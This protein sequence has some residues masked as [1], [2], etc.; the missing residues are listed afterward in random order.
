M[1]YLFSQKRFIID[2]WQGPNANLIY[3]CFII[4]FINAIDLNLLIYL[5]VYFLFIYLHLSD[6][7]LPR[8]T[9][10]NKDIL[11]IVFF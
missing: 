7:C 2:V 8:S 4:I 9:Y 10:L 6:E 3:L 11:S 5:F 1:R